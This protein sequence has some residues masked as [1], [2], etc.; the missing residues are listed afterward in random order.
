MTCT[1][2][3]QSCGPHAGLK[4][5]TTAAGSPRA[6][7]LWCGLE[8]III[9]VYKTRQDPLISQVNLRF[10]WLYKTLKICDWLALH[11][12]FDTRGIY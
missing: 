4:S 1:A 6:L 11:K 9:S 12:F 2:I 3:P 8:R 7:P 5:A 10:R